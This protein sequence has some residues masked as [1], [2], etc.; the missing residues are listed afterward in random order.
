[1]KKWII[2]IALLLVLAVYLGGQGWQRLL[3]NLQGEAAPLPTLVPAATAVP[4]EAPSLTP[5]PTATPKPEPTP[6]PE[7]VRV[8]DGFTYEPVPETV[9]TLMTGK[10]YGEDCDVSWQD[11]RYVKVRHI[12]FDGK[13]HEGELVV[14]ACIAQDV[15]EILYELYKAAYPIEKMRLV[16][17]YEA[18]D[19]ASCADNNSSAFNYRV[20]EGTTRLSKHALGVAVDIN[21]LYNPYV[22]GGKANIPEAE[23]YTDRTKDCPYYIDEEDL[24]YKLFTER[25]FTWGGS[26]RSVKDYQHF[27]R[28]PEE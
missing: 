27:Q 10:S 11:L 21:P 14:N 7:L 4:T 20:V 19:D 9:R 28:L 6:N 1:M 16:D 13:A 22:V 2:P 26:W 25:G 15:T 8:A 18:D 3:N 23:P 24:C 12:G 17:Y 5:E